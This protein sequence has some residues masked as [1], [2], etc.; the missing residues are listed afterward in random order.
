MGDTRKTKKHYASP[1]K[2]WDKT[3]I[4]SEKSVI[5]IYGLKNKRELRRIETIL[6]AKRDNGRK[7]LAFDAE[8]R[9]KRENELMQSLNRIGIFKGPASLDDV[10]SL[11][12]QEFLERRLQT[13]VWR[14]NLAKTIKQ[15]RQFI[16]HGHIAINGKKLDCPSYLVPID[17]ESKIAY[18]KRPIE[19]EPEKAEDKKEEL[20][21]KFGEMKKEKNMEE[22]FEEERGKQVEEKKGE[23][24]EEKKE[25]K[26]EVKE[27]K[28]DEPEVEKS[29]KDSKEEKKDDIMEGK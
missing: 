1:K 25:F 3:R 28:A 11:N 20:K 8:E 5:E 19:M 9:Q 4:E 17:E 2:R 14:K 10:L 6:R 23:K 29:E 24:V 16:V 15:A 18:F 22:I 21:K 7:L 13:I 27:T 12:V 26:V